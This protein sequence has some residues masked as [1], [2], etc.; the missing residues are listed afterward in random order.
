MSQISTPHMMTFAI[1][2]ALPGTRNKFVL[3]SHHAYKLFITEVLHKYNINHL[4]RTAGTKI[5]FSILD[6]S[7][8]TGL[9]FRILS[10]N[11]KLFSQVQCLEI[12]VLQQFLGIKRYENINFYY[13][14]LCQAIFAG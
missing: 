14:W 1:T 13:T 10:L 2:I 11:F 3:I 5:T 4:T 9:F 6:I 12:M 8:A 7:F